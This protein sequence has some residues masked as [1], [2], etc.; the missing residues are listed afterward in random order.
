VAGKIGCLSKN[1]DFVFVSSIPK[2]TM[3]VLEN[4]RSVS[5]EIQ[6]EMYRVIP[7]EKLDC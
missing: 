5:N 3:F 2:R 6:I 7:I 4:C 1:G